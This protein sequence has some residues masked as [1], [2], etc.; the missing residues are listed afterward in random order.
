[1]ASTLT[2]LAV[3]GLLA[4]ANAGV[5]PA[6][7]FG[8][9]P[10]G[11]VKTGTAS[12]TQ[13]RNPKFVRNGPLELARTL[14]KY[15][16]PIPHDLRQ[17]VSRIRKEQ[18]LQRRDGDDDHKGLQTGSGSAEATPQKHDVEYLLPI[19]IGTPGQKLNV[20]L[21]TG[22]SDLWVFS[23]LTYKDQ[24]NG[25]SL[26][27]PNASSTAKKMEGYTWKIAYGDGSSSSGDVYQDTVTVGGVT[28]TTQAVEA[29]R[30]VSAE[31]TADHANDG[32]MGLA[33]GTINTILPRRQ[34]T[35]FENAL[36]GL[37]QPVFT[38]DLKAGAPGHY[39]FGYID[40]SAYKNN[41]TY[42]P[43]DNSDGFWMWDSPGY[44]IGTTASGYN[45]TTIHGIADTGTT[46]LL[47]PGEVVAAYYAQVDGAGYSATQGGYVLPCNSK[48]PALY[49]AVNDDVFVRI[50]GKY[51]AYSPADQSGTQCFGGLQDDSGIGFSIWGDIA[52]KAAFVVFDAGKTQLGWAEKDLS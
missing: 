5:L 20:D 10:N 43:V 51:M 28:V 41:I 27:D 35:W 39:N 44:A 33:F 52:L 4:A 40:S 24:V 13:V 50:P 22:S 16:T 2:T 6:S 31:F 25:Q 1:M 8:P 49:F 36:S 19:S 12:L 3:A 34:P 11:Q 9:A 17:A 18:Q 38:A 46:L 14:R 23:T 45:T 26:Y 7:I 29:A 47:L 30:N 37:D 48:S 21:D 32:L 42:V 15:N